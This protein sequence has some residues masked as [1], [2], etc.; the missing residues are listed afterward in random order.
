MVRDVGDGKN[1]T[2]GP[3][4]SFTTAPPNVAP[5]AHDDAYEL[6]EDNVHIVSAPGVLAND[7]DADGDE[8][9]AVLATGPSH[10][11][12]VANP[13]GGFT[14][15]PAH[16]YHGPDSFTYR[17]TDGLAESNV[18]TVAITVRPVNDVP[19]AVE[20]RFGVDEDQTVSVGALGVLANDSDE[21]GTGLLQAVLVSGASNGTLTLNANGGFAYAPNRDF[22]GIGHVHATGRP[23]VRHRRTSRRST[24]SVSPVNDAP[25]AVNDSVTTNEDVAL[26][27]QRFE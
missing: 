4:W 19:V 22:S 16:N 15:E 6:D 18:V 8:L 24:I 2:T 23:T 10:G 1:T 12:L 7:T 27:G 20:D 5:V 11:S 13:D 9:T 3:I 26:T 17:A 25:I 21:D 14:Y